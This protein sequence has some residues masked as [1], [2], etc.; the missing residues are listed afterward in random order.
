MFGRAIRFPAFVQIAPIYETP[1][2]FALAWIGGKLPLITISLCAFN[3]TVVIQ[4]F[5]RGIKARQGVA[6]AKNAT[7]SF[8]LSLIQLVAKSRRRYGG[9]VVHVGV[10]L[11]F[12]G[13]T[14]RAW[15]VDKEIT[16]AKGD[17]IAMEEYEV[18]YQ[19]THREQD[20][21]K[22]MIFADLEVYRNG[23]YAGHVAPAK[24]MY[25]NMPGSPSTEIARHV[26][27]RNDLYVTLAMANPQTKAASFQ[28]HINPLVSFIWFGVGILI[29]GALISLWPDVQDQEST[30]FSYV[31]AA[32]SVATAVMFSVLFALAP[33]YA[34]GG[35]GSQKEFF[36]DGSGAR[37]APPNGAASL[38]GISP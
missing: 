27:L 35:P 26:T 19:G 34:Y 4:E 37:V 6:R 7:E 23:A 29:C 9:Y 21:E 11:M 36:T 3:V 16:L 30:V 2:G 1:M 12:L 33:S 8:L 13:F 28:F 25:K 18:V 38:G 14:G 32:A 20:P 17:R 5:A 31:R 10:V 15:G 22:M 24:Y